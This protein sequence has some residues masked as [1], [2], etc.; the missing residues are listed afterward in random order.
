[1][2][3]SAGSKRIRSPLAVI[4]VVAMLSGCTSSHNKSA[5]NATQTSTTSASSN[6]T[7]STRSGSVAPCEAADLRATV[8]DV[9]GAAGTHFYLLIFAKTTGGSCSMKGYPGVAPLDSAGVKIGDAARAAGPLTSI[10]LRVGDQASSTLTTSAPACGVPA[11]ASSLLVTPPDTTTSVKVTLP[12]T[13]DVCALMVH[14]LYAG[15]PP[16]S[17]RK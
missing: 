5:R 16:P 12:A 4:A 3:A 15:T 1:M 10:T 14:P 13:T 6:T 9:E 11:N 17:D 2:A 7:T 8:R